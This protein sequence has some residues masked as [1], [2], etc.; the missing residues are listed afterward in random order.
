VSSVLDEYCGD[1][2]GSYLVGRIDGAG[3][4]KFAV[5]KWQGKFYSQERKEK[6]HGQWQLQLR[7][8]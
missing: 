7:A 2:R 3:S 5:G 4:E 8:R 1:G 6:E